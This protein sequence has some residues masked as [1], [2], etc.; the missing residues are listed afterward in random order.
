MAMSSPANLKLLLSELK[1]EAGALLRLLKNFQ[2]LK[3]EK[4]K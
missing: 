1:F 4:E 2:T 3:G